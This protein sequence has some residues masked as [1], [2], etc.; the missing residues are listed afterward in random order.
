MSNRR[1]APLIAV[2]LAAALGAAGV[3]LAWPDDG[4]AS[5]P[6]PDPAAAP[7]TPWA[8]PTADE[9]A[10]L[11]ESG[12]GTVRYTPPAASAPHDADMCRPARPSGQA[13][14]LIHGGGGYTGSREGLEP[15]AR[16]YRSQGL[17]TL[18]VD[19]TL[20]GD[21]TA[22]PVYPAPERDVKAAAQFLRRFSDT[23]GIDPEAILVH[24]SSAGARLGAQALVTGGDPWF[25]SPDLWPDVP[26]HVNGL[27]AFYGYYDGTSLVTEDY[28]GGMP[29]STDPAVQERLVHADSIGQAAGATGPALLFHGDVDGL[30][31][32]SQTERFGRALTES[33]RTATTR[34]L[35]DENHAFDQRPGDPFTAIGRRAAREI[36]DWLPTALP[37]S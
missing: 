27:V 37:A 35:V 31:D 34:I 2:A 12:C 7:E 20:V 3:L 10:A 9:V 5:G 17:V 15:W 6:G 13:V 29:T 30:V 36:L 33:G 4:T 16:W 26:D 1:I 8:R 22:P 21:G 32:V 14:V 11:P 25:A 19:Y 28:L 24:G 23:L 18:A